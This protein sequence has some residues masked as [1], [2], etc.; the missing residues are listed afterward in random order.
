[1]DRRFIVS[2]V[3][4]VIVGIFA[5]ANGEKVAIDFIFKKVYTSQALIILISALLGALIVFLISSIKSMRLKQNIKKMEKEIS[6]LEEKNESLSKIAD[7]M[8][9]EELNDYEDLEAL[10]EGGEESFEEE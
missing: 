9:I 7:E 1:M 10:E 6:E 2:L 4:A 3:F 5:L 8:I